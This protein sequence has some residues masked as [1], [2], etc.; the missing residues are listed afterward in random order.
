MSTTIDKQIKGYNLCNCDC[1][2]KNETIHP[3]TCVNQVLVGNGSIPTLDDWLRYKI[4]DDT[5]VDIGGFADYNNFSAWLEDHTD[6]ITNSLDYASESTFGLV[7]IGE[8]INVDKGVISVTFPSNPKEVDV[9]T[10]NALNSVKLGNDTYIPIDFTNSSSQTYIDDV[11]NNSY[12]FPLRLTENDHAGIAIDKNLLGSTYHV[13]DATHHA[14]G[15]AYTV[16]GSGNNTDMFLKGDGTWANPASASYNVFAVGSNGLVPAPAQS[17]TGKF[18]TG[19]STW[20]SIK[21]VYELSASSVSM[22]LLDS[23]IAS[24]QSLIDSSGIFDAIQYGGYQ[25]VDFNFDGP[26][27]K[28]SEEDYFRIVP[29]INA[30]HEYVFSNFVDHHGVLKITFSF[31]LYTAQ[32]V[33]LMFSILHGNSTYYNFE[34]LGDV[35]YDTNYMQLTCAPNKKY[36]LTFEYNTANASLNPSVTDKL[37]SVRVSVDNKTVVHQS[38]SF[39]L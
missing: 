31:Q 36:T 10:Y 27:Q 5:L 22:G 7:K 11:D 24:I 25:E 8:N 19:G 18:L 34:I 13:L 30:I 37:Y 20:R 12:Y 6:V 16:N 38:S 29:I 2:E 3:E 4:V 39:A 9:A 14:A 17:N 21:S 32:N 35:A 26:I 28:A 23:Y 33:S 1:V 15:T